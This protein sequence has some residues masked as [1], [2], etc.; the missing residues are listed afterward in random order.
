M[1]NVAAAAGALALGVV[2]AGCGHTSH[3]QVQP[4]LA[5]APTWAGC[6]GRSVESIDYVSGAHGKPTALAALASYRTD[7]DHVVVV[8]AGSSQRR[9]W[10]LVGDRNVIHTALGMQHGR[11]GWLVDLVEKCSRPAGR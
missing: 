2:L 10:L 7:G 11:N 3:P 6:H 4:D 9:Q 1:R 8:P 5:G